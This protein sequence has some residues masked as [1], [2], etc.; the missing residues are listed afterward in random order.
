MARRD[1]TVWATSHLGD[2]ALCLR[3]HFRDG[4]VHS[5]SPRGSSREEPTG[6]LHAEKGCL[7]H[8]AAIANLYSATKTVPLPLWVWSSARVT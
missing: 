3:R 4:G 5:R 2:P 6:A 1:P 8:V 7:L